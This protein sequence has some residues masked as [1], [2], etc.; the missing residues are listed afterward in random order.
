M[1]SRCGLAERI[2]FRALI[3]ELNAPVDLVFITIFTGAFFFV[4]LR[5]TSAPFTRK[6]VTT[7]SMRTHERDELGRGMAQ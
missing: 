6:K 3:L 4:F 7:G 1:G 5:S 2:G